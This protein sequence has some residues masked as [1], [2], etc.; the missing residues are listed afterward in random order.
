MAIPAWAPQWYHDAF[1]KDPRR[2]MELWARHRRTERRQMQS[3][4]AFARTKAF[5]EADDIAMLTCPM[6]AA[7]VLGKSK[8]ECRAA[9]SCFVCGGTLPERRLYWCSD[10]CVRRWTTNHEWSAASRER[11]RLDRERCVRCGVKGGPTGV[12]TCELD[13]DPFP[14]AV[15]QANPDPPSSDPTAYGGPEYVARLRATRGHW[16]KTEAV[17]L[18]VNHVDPRNGRGYHQG[19]HH[20]LDRLES[21]C[22]GCH[23]EETNA[24]RAARGA[25]DEL[26][27]PAAYLTDRA[28]IA[29]SVDSHSA[30]SETAPPAALPTEYGSTLGIP[31]A[32]AWDI[33][34]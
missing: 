30:P 34:S 3:D 26:E 18:E 6:R 32:G 19:C 7:S 2:G 20:H 9:R 29:P 4:R 5:R 25:V 8:E 27:A 12:V 11:V 16:Q 24:Q 10:E 23:V 22:H 15:V 13:G 33:A 17:V 14:C 21:L 1:A 28:P 31:S